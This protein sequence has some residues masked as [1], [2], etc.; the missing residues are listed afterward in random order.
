LAVH[1]TCKLLSAM[2][3]SSIWHVIW[4][5]PNYSSHN[6]TNTFTSSFFFLIFFSFILFN[7]LFILYYKSHA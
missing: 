1:C 6:A 3:N 5:H 2:R 7:T 4:L